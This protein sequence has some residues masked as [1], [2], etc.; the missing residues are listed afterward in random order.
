[1]RNAE[2]IATS[3]LLSEVSEVPAVS[4]CLLLLP[5]AA[6]SRLQPPR[7]LRAQGGLESQAGRAG[8]EGRLPG[9]RD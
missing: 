1:M 9:G 3:Q 5:V 2:I 7:P 6:G 4:P 8:G